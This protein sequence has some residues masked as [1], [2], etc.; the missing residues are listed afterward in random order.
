MHQPVREHLED[1]LQNALSPKIPREFHAHLEACASC[2][3]EVG[4]MRD[5]SLL[6]RSLRSSEEVDPAAGFYARVMETI[7]A[8]RSASIWTAFLDPSFGRRLVFASLT[9]LV[10]IGTYIVT[11]E[12][13]DTLTARSPEVILAAQPGS[14]GVVGHDRER[15]RQAVLVTLA[16]YRE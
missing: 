9:L 11:T 1:Y 16:T 12:P 2:R 3:D 8:Q 5:H 13:Q 15:N 6:V 4:R 7:D 14:Y 10:L